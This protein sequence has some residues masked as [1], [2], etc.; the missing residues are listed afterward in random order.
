MG[1]DLTNFLMRG[2]ANAVTGNELARF[3]GWNRRD[4]TAHINA[5][6]KGGTVICS[7][8]RGYFFPADK[9]EVTAFVRNMN[10][11]IADMRSATQSAERYLQS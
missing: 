6:R 5:L 1:N 4:V 9:G 8:T 2:E 11:R 3:M 7:S 10:S